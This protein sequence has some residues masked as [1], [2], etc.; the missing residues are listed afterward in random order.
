MTVL[1]KGTLPIAAGLMA[2]GA[3]RAK[4]RQPLGIKTSTKLRRWA[5]FI[6]NKK[7]KKRKLRLKVKKYMK[8]KRQRKIRKKHKMVLKQ[9]LP[10]ELNSSLTY[11]VTSDR[12]EPTLLKN[13][14]GSVKLFNQCENPPKL[15]A[16]EWNQYEYHKLYK[17]SW[18]IHQRGQGE[19]KQYFIEH[20]KLHEVP[21][22]IIFV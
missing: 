1:G 11:T 20:Y 15:V 12:F 5:R 13:E 9:K 21:V 19:N 22:P 4:W 7:Q 3:K 17:F 18:K 2:Y 14:L 8:R 16:D 6:A 10:L